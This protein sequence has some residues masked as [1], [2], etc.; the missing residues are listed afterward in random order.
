MAQSSHPPAGS[1]AG[2]LLL[3]DDEPEICVL[4]ADFLR[5]VGYTVESCTCGAE[6]D[7]ALALG[8]ADLVLLDV[9]MPR[10]DGLSIARRLRAS[11]PMPIMMMTSLNSVL[12]RIV[13]YEVGADDYLAKPFDMRELLARVRAVLRRAALT[14]GAGAATAVDSGTAC[15]GKVFLDRA[16]RCLVDEAGARTELTATEYYLLDTFAQNPNRVLTRDRLFDN[17]PGRDADRIERAVDIRINRIRRKV[18]VDPAKPMVI[19]TIRHV[20]YIYVPPRV[21]Q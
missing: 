1:E 5:R 4:V 8:A 3:V 16:Q 10:E 7:A 21:T 18:E 12:D 20:G 19:R 9:S 15:F 14:C 11:G 2:R 13:G 6:L 17:L